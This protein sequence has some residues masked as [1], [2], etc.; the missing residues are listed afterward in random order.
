MQEIERLGRFNFFALLLLILLS[1]W[2]FDYQEYPESEINSLMKKGI[3]NLIIQKFDEAQVYFIK[4]NNNYPK[5]P[6]GKIY[7]AANEI[8]RSYDQAGDYNSE[9]IL[10]NLLGAIE[11]AEELVDK[12][13]NNVWNIY[14]LAL[15]EGY[16]AYF[17]ALDGNWLSA[18]SNG[19][20]CVSNFEK[21]IEIDSSFYEAYTAI[22]AYKYWKSRKT[23]I[24]SW[25]SLFSDEK[26]EGI[27]LLEEA[28]S[29]TSYNTYLAAYT[30][31][32]IYIDSK[33][34]K[35]AVRISE[36]VIKKYPDSRFFKW[37]YARAYEGYNRQKSI[38][39]YSSLLNSYMQENNLIQEIILKH[40]IA[41]QHQ[42]L[43]NYKLALSFCNDIL[44]IKGLTESQTEKLEDRLARVRELKKL[45]SGD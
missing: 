8:A 6:L 27:A 28:I 39:I 31:Q 29:K 9:F 20:S 7:L 38:E 35:N 45:L 44:S 26:S 19:L 2:G 12:D 41:Q 21:C 14:M 17:K 33:E 40:I 32:W 25:L 30:L 36:E 10:K 34:Y 3:D 22:G 1:S 15:A 37:G 5:N 16:Y 4:L 42:H 13:E 23:E 24:A 43:G 18:F 11:Q